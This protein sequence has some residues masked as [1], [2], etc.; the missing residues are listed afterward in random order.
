MNEDLENRLSKVTAKRGGHFL[1][2]PAALP[3]DP[4]AAAD[5][6]ARSLR[7]RPIGQAWEQVRADLAAATLA[8]LLHQWLAYPKEFMPALEAQSLAEAFVGAFGPESVCLTNV[9]WYTGEP[10]ALPDPN[11]PPYSWQPVTKST[12]DAGVVCFGGGQVGLLWFE[13]ED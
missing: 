8:R 3:E 13:E 1:L 11:G 6:L 12:F 5:D 7:F 4:E 2:R 9:K 10:G